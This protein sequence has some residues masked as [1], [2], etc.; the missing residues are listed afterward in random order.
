MGTRREFQ[1]YMV[2]SINE[3][4]F[5]FNIWKKVDIVNNGKKLKKIKMVLQ[6]Y[7]YLQFQDILI[8]E[9]H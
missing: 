2:E 4:S 6:T 9:V 5:A 8:K 1:D 7:P 3:K